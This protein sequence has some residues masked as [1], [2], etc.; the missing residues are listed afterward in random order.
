MVIRGRKLFAPK[1]EVQL[2]GHTLDQVIEASYLGS[3]FNEK[4]KPES[5]RRVPNYKKE[6]YFKLL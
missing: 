4:P 1:F 2:L 5:F 3:N 6:K